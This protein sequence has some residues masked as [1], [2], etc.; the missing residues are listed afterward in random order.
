MLESVV[1]PLKDMLR[2][3][4]TLLHVWY[5]RSDIAGLGPTTESL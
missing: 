1:A 2:D 3:D 5:H 4:A